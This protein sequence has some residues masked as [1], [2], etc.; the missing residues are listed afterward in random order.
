MTDFQ[1]YR[2]RTRDVQD[3]AER[4]VWGEL[5]Q[6]DGAGAVLR[7]RGTGTVDE[8][9][10][11]ANFGY[12][13]TLAVD[14]NAEVFA[15]SHGSDTN[16]KYA[17]PMIPRDKQRQWPVG[18]G[19]V[20][21]PMNPEMY[22]EFADDG[23]H[24]RNGTF[25]IGPDKGVRIDVGDGVVNFVCAELRHNGINIGDTHRHGG[26]ISGGSLTDGPVA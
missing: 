16:Q 4:M 11:I 9:M 13:F 15:L 19:G 7:A 24:L 1:R 8:E 5:R 23:I 12:G 25:F 3:Y 22:V 14:T 17:L 26:V 10:P 6:I 18:A 20:Q 2:E 21:H